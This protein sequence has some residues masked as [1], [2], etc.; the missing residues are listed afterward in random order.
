MQQAVRVGER[1]H[2]QLPNKEASL[3]VNFPAKRVELQQ[4]V[5]RSAPPPLNMP[6]T[7]VQFRPKDDLTGAQEPFFKRGGGE[8]RKSSF[9]T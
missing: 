7:R 5:A 1:H 6:T 2:N 3:V 4:P 8:G 9:I